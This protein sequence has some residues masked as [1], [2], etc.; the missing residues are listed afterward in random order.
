MLGSCSGL[1][2]GD[3]IRDTLDDEEAESGAGQQYQYYGT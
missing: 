1:D 3:K 2:K